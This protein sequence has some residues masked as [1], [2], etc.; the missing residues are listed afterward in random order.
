MTAQESAVLLM[1][2]LAGISAT[3]VLLDQW[4]RRREQRSHKRSG[5]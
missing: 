2:L 3:V 4:G 5:H 1:V